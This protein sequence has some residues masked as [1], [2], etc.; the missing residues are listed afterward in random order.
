M[1]EVVMAR[2]SKNTIKKT[3]YSIV[4]LTLTIIVVIIIINNPRYAVLAESL[5]V[6]TF[7]NGLNPYIVAIPGSGLNGGALIVNADKLGQLD[8]VVYVAAD[9]GP[10]GH[11]RS[12]SMALDSDNQQYN[13]TIDNYFEDAQSVSGSIEITTTNDLTQTLTSGKRDYERWP[14]LREQSNRLITKD[15]K[16]SMLLDAETLPADI[17]FVLAVDTFAPVLP[18]AGWRSISNAYSIQAS[19]SIAQASR[20]YLLTVVYQP[21]LLGDMD[22][23]LLKLFWFNPTTDAWEEAGGN[24][25]PERNDVVL[26]TERFGT[27]M[28]FAPAPETPTPTPTDTP[29]P[30]ATPTPTPTPTASNTA[31][32]TP[33]LTDTPTATSTPIE[34]DHLFLPIVQNGS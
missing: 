26:A 19:G 20:P 11:L 15:G 17:A 30:T 16:L 14:V 29:T 31:T 1:L 34:P 27:F 3:Y 33:T 32:P 10:T 6:S 5:P 18:P 28:L 8:T 21:D 12:H 23:N 25:H 13:Y 7:E 24:V 22:P 9:Q 2:L 4:S